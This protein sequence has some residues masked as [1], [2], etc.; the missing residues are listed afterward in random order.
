MQSTSVVHLFTQP[1]VVLPT[2]LPRQR[3]TFSCKVQHES[4]LQFY[5]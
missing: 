4:Q 5:G 3:T 1:R 2:S